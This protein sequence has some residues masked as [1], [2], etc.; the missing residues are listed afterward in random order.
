MTGRRRVTT[1]LDDELANG[2]TRVINFD[3]SSLATGLYFINIVGEH[4]AM[5]EKVVLVK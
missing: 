3:A 1:L 2:V 5:T 4:F